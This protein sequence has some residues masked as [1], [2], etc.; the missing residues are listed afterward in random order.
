MRWDWRAFDALTPHALYAAMRLRQQ[1]FVIE[2]ACLFVDADGHDV[3]AWHLLGWLDDDEGTPRL[4][5]YA[6][7]FA[8]GVI[9]AETSIG[10]IATDRTLRG[11]GHGRALVHEALRRAESLAPG[12]P[13]RIA[14]QRHLEP[15]YAAFGFQ[16][17]GDD[18][19]ED[20][21]PH[22]EMVRRPDA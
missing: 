1:V 17:A 12:A 13:V 19:I 22:V 3:D 14:A 18:F 9:F 21:I 20:G 6:R 15:F 7:V 10:R 5:A 4:A 11:A 2:Q 16:R 8:P